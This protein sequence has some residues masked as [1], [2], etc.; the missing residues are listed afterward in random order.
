MTMRSA[1]HFLLNPLLRGSPPNDAMAAALRD[2]GFEVDLFAPAPGA[3]G[4]VI[5]IEY[6][7]RCIAR[8]AASPRWR[9][10]DVMSGT[11]E[12]PMALV[13][14]LS[15]LH[16]RPSICLADEIYSGSYAGDRTGT[17]KALCRSGMRNARLTIVNDPS[18]VELQ[19]EYA[20]LDPA[21]PTFVYPGAFR[22]TPAPGDR[23][24]LRR[25]R[26]I[27]ADAVVV[28]YSGVFNLGNGGLWL[29][30]LLERRTDLHVWGQ[31]V[32]V[33]PLARGLLGRLRGAERL[34][35]EPRRLDW[36]E[37][38]VSMAA[39]DVGVVVY[40]QDGPQFRN[41]GIASNRLCMF[42]SMG[43]P[44]VASRQASF[45]FIERYEC[46]VLVDGED[47]FVRAFD[48][49]LSDL[50]RMKENAQACARDFIQAPRRFEGL[51]AAIATVVRA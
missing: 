38:W 51:R 5:P 35:L 31:L 37:S 13:G 6:G 36:R 48:R 34:H 2:L 23:E 11:T 47:G 18:R 12:D 26:G 8:E 4:D 10:Y 14:V 20:R 41:M 19:R 39:A 46:G 9:R 21:R 43:L 30:A 40:L 15:R 33:D 42:L 44:V 50:P 49:V 25:E 24:A 27:P 22:E 32:D 29:S 16:G 28:C 7:Y 17:W 1:A 3:Q 45:E